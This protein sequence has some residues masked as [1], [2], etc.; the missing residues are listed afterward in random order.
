MR[1]TKVNIAKFRGFENQSFEIGSHLTAIAGQNGTQKSTLLGILTQT[2]TLGKMNPMRAEKPLCGGSYISAFKDKFRL[3]P[4]FDKPKQHEW[5]ISFDDGTPDFT[6][7][8]IARTGSNN[9]RFWQKGA[10]QAGDGYVTFPT[11]FLSLKRLMPAAEDT[12]LKTDD[13][14]LTNDEIKKFQELHNR[15]LISQTPISSTTAITSKNK[16]SVGVSTNLYDWN[17]NSMGQDNLGKIILA[18]FSFQRLQNKFPNQYNGGILAIDELDATM[19]PA[20]QVELLKV[21]RSYAASLK[22]QIIFTTHSISL[23]RAFDKFK[24]ETLR[25]VETK[26][27]IKLLYLKRCDEK[28]LIKTDCGIKAIDLDLHVIAVNQKSNKCKITVYSEDN[29]NILFAKSILKRRTTHLN[30]IYV[31]ISCSELID[32]V[33]RK[34]PAFCKPYSIIILDGDVKQDKEKRRKL[35]DANNVLLLPGLLS[36]ERLVAKF[37]F[38][39]SDA[40][41]LWEQLANGYS[42]QV[43]FRQYS[44][45]QISANGE[46]GRQNAKKWFNSQLEFWGRNGV[47]VLNPV[48]NSMNQ[49]RV[50]FIQS[51][52]KLIAGYVYD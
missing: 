35:K 6:V 7:E 4:N 32:M 27:Q 52:D 28:I 34:V 16:Q 12:G 11:I 15:I 40:N 51:F 20:S 10:R 49:E 13:N 9:I 25:R 33:Y 41:P 2:F 38:E 48:L 23:L 37:L 43:C 50:D 5:T 17:Q 36:P 21:L 18:L 1:I 45:E 26:N 44:Y 29:E 3:S 14:L 46:Q 22:L 39:L 30:F 47:K 24:Q 19:Y 31:S 8:S 42:K